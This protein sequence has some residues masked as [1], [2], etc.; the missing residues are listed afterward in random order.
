LTYYKENFKVEEKEV[1]YD[2]F[3]KLVTANAK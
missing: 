1:T 3:I 2:D